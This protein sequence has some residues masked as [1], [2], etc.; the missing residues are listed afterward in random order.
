MTGEDE[1]TPPHSPHSKAL[2]QH[3]ERK[4][5]LHA[6]HLDEDVQVTNERIGQMETTQV[7]TNTRLTTL[8]RSIGD[9]NASLAAILNR[10]EKMDR[11]KP[12]KTTTLWAALWV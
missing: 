2:L 9:V 7:D 5:R 1:R 6:E 10:L 12:Q 4:V 11:A 8:E 3:F